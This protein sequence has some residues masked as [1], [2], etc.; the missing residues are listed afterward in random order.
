MKQ[1]WS[2]INQNS[3]TIYHR[4]PSLPGWPYY[5]ALSQIKISVILTFILILLTTY[6]HQSQ[7]MKPVFFFLIM[8]LTFSA[9]TAQ[10]SKPHPTA[11][12][13]PSERIPYQAYL[14]VY[15]TGNE[16]SIFFALSNDGYHYKALNGGRPVMTGDTLGSTGGVRDPHILRSAEGKT[17]YMVATDMVAANGWNSNRAMVL[18]KSQDLIHW[19]HSVVNIQKSYPGQD[20]LLRAWAPQTIYDKKTKKYMI[21]W[22]MK[23]GSNAPDKIYYAYANSDFTAL[24][25]APELLFESPSNKACID[26]D[27]MEKD[28]VY[29]LFFKT[30][31]NGDGIKQAISTNLTSGY[32]QQPPYLQQT[33]KPVEG[34]CIFKLNDGSGYI[35]MYDM[36]TSRKYQFTFSKDLNH[37]EVVD[38]DVSMD[39]HPRHGTVMPI[40]TAEA[41][42]LA[43]H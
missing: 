24:E 15:F 43:M 23:H 16:E 36:Y 9:V 1:V 37:F 39:F 33:K 4:R 17:F 27:I 2:A 38:K 26:A 11:K 10:H 6:I 32:V 7:P 8:Q 14:F 34:S 5:F 18:M 21:Y 42:R 20:S 40:T 31:G 12:T 3:A 41:R 22:A 28:G 30:E 29:H 35:L 25:G 13:S 19:S